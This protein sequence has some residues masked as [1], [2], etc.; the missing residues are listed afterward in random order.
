VCESLKIPCNI[1]FTKYV[2]A[3]GENFRYQ[4]IGIDISMKIRHLKRV[5][6]S[7]T[8]IDSACAS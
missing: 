4:Q 1:T 8:L 7:V 5:V 3:K 2:Q 6:H